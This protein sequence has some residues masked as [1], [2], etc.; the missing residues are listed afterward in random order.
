MVLRPGLTEP[1][2]RDA[3]KRVL[4]LAP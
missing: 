2:I 3:A 4:D 1:E